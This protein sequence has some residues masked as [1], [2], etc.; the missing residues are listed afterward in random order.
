MADGRVLTLGALAAL[1]LTSTV[2]RG[3]R[4]RLG[5]ARY[6]DQFVVLNVQSY[7]EKIG[8]KV[9]SRVSEYVVFDRDTGRVRRVMSGRGA[10]EVPLRWSLAHFDAAVAVA[11][12]LNAGRRKPSRV[13]L[14]TPEG[15]HY[16]EEA[17]RADGW[18]ERVGSMARMAPRKR[19]IDIRVVEF[20]ISVRGSEDVPRYALYNPVDDCIYRS[21]TSDMSRFGDR[22]V[23]LARMGDL[24][25]LFWSGDDLSAYAEWQGPWL[26]RARIAF[27][28]QGSAAR[29]ISRHQ[30]RSSGAVV[31]RLDMVT[32]VERWAVYD[33]VLDLTM[34]YHGVESYP[35]EAAA[36][37]ARSLFVDEPDSWLP[38][39]DL[40]L[41]RGFLSQAR[42]GYQL[43]LA[44]QRGGSRARIAPPSRKSAAPYMFAL[45]DPFAMVDTDLFSILPSSGVQTVSDWNELYCGLYDPFRNKVIAVGSLE[46][47]R[48]AGF[49]PMFGM[50]EDGTDFEG[51]RLDEMPVGFHVD[52]SDGSI[53][54]SKTTF[55][56]LKESARKDVLQRIAGLIHIYQLG[57]R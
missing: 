17:R 13:E 39:A 45:R 24:E 5:P 33:P 34:F 40:T 46:Y 16:D 25:D 21:P 56:L 30:R 26:E 41:P 18:T 38:D 11:A 50:D 35:S 4:A 52:M 47:A 28:G 8:A 55:P 43:Q 6:R 54:L 27:R 29:L 23:A 51:R 53:Q 1:A 48:T 37:A 20:L 3:S 14:L 7:G 22:E 10:D 12:E 15:L 44:A 2:A 57:S 32:K 31:V 9:A 36:E 42:R 49:E 19:K